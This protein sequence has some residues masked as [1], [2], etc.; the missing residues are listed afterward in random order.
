VPLGRTYTVDSG[1]VSIA[2]A[3]TVQYVMA[4]YTTTTNVADIEAIRV[5]VYSAAG[6]TASY[7]ANATLLCQLQRI[8]TPGTSSQT[9][10]PRPHN[11]ADLAAN[12]TWATGT[13]QTTPAP[14]STP[15]VLW[16]QSLPLTAGAN[17]AEWVT[18]GA[19]WRLG[20][21][22]N[23]AAAAYV[24]LF[25]QASVTGS[26]IQLVAEIVFSE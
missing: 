9:V 5:G 21:V 13:F 26:N 3:T 4:A 8:T 23:S 1:T 11:Q 12:T 25:V 16:G 19:E 6:A 24:A 20:P 10:V 7:S 18:P 17:W 14:Q 15:V 2:T 22:S